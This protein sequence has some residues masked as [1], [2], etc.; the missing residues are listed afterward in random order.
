LTGTHVE[1]LAPLLDGTR[2]LPALVRD[3]PAGVTPD[4]LASVL[5]QLSEAGLV[6]MRGPADIARGEPTTPRERALGYWESCGLE[7]TVAASAVA[8]KQLRL[9]TVGGVDDAAALAAFRAAGLHCTANDID[10]H[11]GVGSADLSVVLCDDYLNLRL[12]DVDAEHRFAGRPWLLARPVG[13]QLWIGPVFEPDDGA[14]WHCLATRLWGHRQAEAHVQAMLGQLGPARKPVVT[15]PPFT[16]TGMH[17][18]TLEVTKWLAGFRYPGQRAVW[19]LDS[20][21]LSG[22]RHEVRRRPQCAMCGNPGHMRAQAARPVHIASRRKVT[23]SGGG[24]RAMPAEEVLARYRH[25]ISP[26]TGVVREITRD[27]RG[28]MFFNS[29][30][31]GPNLALGSRDIRELRTTLRAENGGKGVT[32]L[33]G[34]VSALCEAL[35]RHSG[36]FHGDEERVRASYRELGSGAVHPDTCQLFDRRQFANRWTWNRAHSPFQHVPDPFDDE[37]LLDWTPVWS[38]GRQRHR[39]LPTG[40]LYYNAPAEPD[41]C[42]VRADSNGAAAGSS[43]EDAILQGLLELVERDAVALWWYNRT[44]Q[45]E[46]DIDAFA[47]PW[48]AELREVYAGL[49]REVWVLDVT[50][51]LGVPTMAALSRRLDRTCE[52][53]MFGF[54]A[55]LDPAVAL[56]RALTELNQLMPAVVNVDEHQQYGWLDK[57]ATHWWRTATVANQPY[58][59]PDRG[60]R[61]RGPGWFGYVPGD[62]LAD[63]IELLRRRLADRDLELLVLD[64]TRPDI[65]LPVVKVV[66]PGLRSMWARFAPGRLFDVP[67]SLGRLPRPTAYGNLNPIPLFI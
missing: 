43:L 61:P 28:P 63:D 34:E 53:I 66:V 7:P 1:A 64:Q 17:L 10:N 26:V 67:V 21:D 54:G 42:F 18:I 46:V 25:L 50:S 33:D 41:W 38:P 5:I 51:D 32:A 3:L 36:Y 24:H 6:T 29:F 31:A 27:R 4:Q 12:A 49:G 2:D 62:D 60:E 45:P 35:E 20:V 11:N 13:R 48:L 19:T 30:R 57:E 44:R 15:V 58:L 55:H 37:A 39:Y 47:D 14:C 65:G 16:A 9:V 52:D 40:M 59:L 56:R 23:R 22:Q 8:D